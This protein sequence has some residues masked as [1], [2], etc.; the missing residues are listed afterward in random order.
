MQRK[1]TSNPYNLYLTKKVKDEWIQM[2]HAIIKGASHEPK[3]SIIELKV[4]EGVEERTLVVD[5]NMHV[6]MKEPFAKSMEA[7]NV[8][9]RVLLMG[10][11][12]KGVSK[13]VIVCILRVTDDLIENENME[14]EV[15]NAKKK[16]QA[17][18][19]M[20]NMLTGTGSSR[21]ASR[22]APKR[23][24]P[25]GGSTM[26]FLSKVFLLFLSKQPPRLPPRNQPQ[27][28]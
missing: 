9:K 23:R 6:F 28:L 12:N 16:K 22:E 19:I 4:L 10:Y 14:R 20:A 11:L 15:V 24:A 2:P 7:I 1:D 3:L 25:A 5:T 21:H 13:R 17:V 27:A 18:D 8:D 26:F